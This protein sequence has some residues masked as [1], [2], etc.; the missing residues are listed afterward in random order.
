MQARI[1][2]VGNSLVP[3]Y[4][5]ALPASDPAKVHFRFKL[6]D[7]KLFRYALSLASGI[8]LVPY[9]AVERVQNDAQLAAILADAIACAIEKRAYSW[10]S[11][12][13]NLRAVLMLAEVADDPLLGLS[14]VVTS[15]KAA[16]GNF[17]EGTHEHSG[18]VSLCLLHDA[19]YDIY[20]APIAW[21]L[22][23][24]KDPKPIA[25]IRLPDHAAYLYRILGETWHNPAANAT[26]AH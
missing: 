26:P 20:Q 16:T 23:A 18:R 6:I 3:A 22:L 21:W 9:E 1:E 10:S 5:L 8:I 4:Q 15:A 2:R 24:S 17:L 13:G 19:G 25:E 14:A 11:S 7:T 12:L